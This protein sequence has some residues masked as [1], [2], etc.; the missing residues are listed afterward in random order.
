MSPEAVR[1]TLHELGVHQIELELQ[2]EELRRA[3]VELDTSRARYFDLYDL[4]PVGY[5][6]VSEPGLILEANLTACALLGLARGKVAARSLVGQ[7]FF[8]FIQKED[9]NVFR[10]F[11]RQSFETGESQ[12]CDVRMLKPDGTP[13]W[14]HLEATAAQDVDGAPVCRV[15]LSDITA[16]KLAEEALQSSLREKVA[17]LNEVHH[18]VKNNL[19]VIT[20]LLRLVEGRSEHPATKSVLQEMSVRIL[21]IALLHESLYRSGTFASV[22]LGAYLRKLTDQSFSAQVVRPD[23]IRFQLDLASVQIEMDQAM[24]CGLL[25]NELV[26]NSLKH[27]FPGDRS[28]EVRVELQPI[29]GGPQFRLRVSDTG[30]GLPADFE[31]KQGKSLG[32]KLVS[33]LVQQI[34]GR[35]EIGSGP[36]AVFEVI[37]L[38]KHS[39]SEPSNLPASRLDGRSTR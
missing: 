9:S 2:N 4:A 14:A 18:R 34:G 7:P 21:A 19:H 16:R 28:G 32:L 22:D 36:G 15:T 31:S 37:F 29:D 25:V 20:S 13:F 8:L 26:S 5:V 11:H 6:T 24:P 10:L 27:G 3:Q 23:S 33:N 1:Q 39:K 17:L 35:L 38:P 30:V 12:A